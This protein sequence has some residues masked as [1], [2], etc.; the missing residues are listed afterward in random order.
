[1]K[2][3]PLLVQRTRYQLQARVRSAKTCP[4]ILFTR[5]VGHLL[6]W[7]FAHP[8]LSGILAPLAPHV[9]EYAQRIQDD[10]RKVRT[11]AQ[12]EIRGPWT[13]EDR[14]SATA[15][16]LAALQ[17]IRPMG[18]IEDDLFTGYVVAL[19]S[20]GYT[21]PPHKN[22]TPEGVIDAFRDVCVQALYEYLD[23]A[24]DSRNA[25][26]SLLLKYKT[27]CEM[28]RRQ[29]LRAAAEE[30]LEGRRGERALAF[31]LYEYLHDQGVDFAIEPVS[32]S[33]EPDLV[34]PIGRGERLVADAKYVGSVT[35]VKRTVASGFRQ[36]LD[37]CRDQNEPVGYLVV[38]LNRDVV[39]SLPGERDDA[40]P[41]VRA[42]GNTVYYV[43][44]DIFDHGTAASKR[45]KPTEVQVAE[46]E[47]LAASDGERGSTAEP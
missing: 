45:P 11:K 23:E 13:A 4:L 16:S 17:T 42:G 28:Y 37:Y 10:L 30:G 27:R 1:M 29:R 9:E 41:C 21:P 35:D 20:A 2:M 19:V 39:L 46:A 5:N 32:A 24:I 18:L 25:V 6:D 3:D 31:D 8:A 15:L 44:I 12:S 47:I 14:G 38:F 36:V 40:F 7:I 26:L 34:S 33:G 22:P 43:F